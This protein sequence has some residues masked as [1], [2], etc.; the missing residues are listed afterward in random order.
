ML[1]PKASA[2]PLS[3]PFQRP[4]LPMFHALEPLLWLGSDVQMMSLLTKLQAWL[5]WEYGNVG[6]KLMPVLG[7]RESVVGTLRVPPVPLSKEWGIHAWNCFVHWEWRSQTPSCS[8]PLSMQNNPPVG[9]Q[10]SVPQWSI[11]YSGSWATL[12][13]LSTR[14]RF[15]SNIL[16]NCILQEIFILK[17]LQ[18]RKT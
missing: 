11:I 5:F 4:F 18:G 9:Q 1:C 13:T 7:E 12:F 8:W 6:I 10:E 16:K 15:C 2:E 3:P 14:Q 17:L